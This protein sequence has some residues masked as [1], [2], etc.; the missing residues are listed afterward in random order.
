M[1]AEFSEGA[2]Q[3]HLRAIVFVILSTLGIFLPDLPLAA[4][5]CHLGQSSNVTSLGYHE[6][7]EV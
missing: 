2:L 1:S 7:E 5:L 4:S 6:C 3:S